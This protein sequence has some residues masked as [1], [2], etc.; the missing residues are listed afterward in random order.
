[1]D[2]QQEGFDFLGYHFSRN[3]AGDVRRWPRVKSMAKVKDTLRAKTRRTN[4]QS[5]AVTIVQ[6][7]RTLKGW[8]GYFKHS[9]WTTF[10]SLDGWVRMRLRSILRKRCGRRGRGRGSDHQRWPNAFFAERKLYSLMT[11]YVSA[12]QPAKAV[13]H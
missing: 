9:L 11:A 10:E 1:M 2:T 12:C 6:V 13:K 5:L 3:Q 4:G 8:F 7:N